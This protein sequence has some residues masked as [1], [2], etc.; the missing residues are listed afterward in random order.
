LKVARRFARET[1]RGGRVACAGH[2]LG[3][4]IQIALVEA[5]SHSRFWPKTAIFVN[6]DDPQAGW[7]HVDGHRSLCLV[8]SP[9]AKRR[10]VA[11]QFYNQLSVLHTMEHILGLPS[12]AQ[13]TAQAPTMEACFTGTPALTVYAARPNVIPLDERNQQLNTLQGV[14]RIS[15]RLLSRASSSVTRP[16]VGVLDRHP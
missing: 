15:S 2:E 7:D 10:A 8:V 11:G 5:V 13:L 14:A 6:E 1:R 9:Y 4:S 16:S 12:T 3:Q